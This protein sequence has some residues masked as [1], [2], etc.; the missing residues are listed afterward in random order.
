MF[1]FIQQLGIDVVHYQPD[2]YKEGYGISMA[3]VQSAKNGN[4][5]LV[6]ALDCGIK[7]IEQSRELKK[8]GIELIISAL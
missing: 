6:I 4:I 7:A 2:R 3:G 1:Q 5:D 8:A